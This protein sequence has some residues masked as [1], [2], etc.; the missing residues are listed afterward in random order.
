MIFFSF[1]LGLSVAGVKPKDVAKVSL[2]PAVVRHAYNDAQIKVVQYY[3]NIRFVYEIESKVR[4][5]K[6]ANTPAEPAEQ[7]QNPKNNTSGN[8][9]RD[10]I[11]ITRRITTS[12]CLPR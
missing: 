7:K 11:G 4:E 8:R 5:L 2:R 1:S 9:N 6:R 10:K 3:D 12:R